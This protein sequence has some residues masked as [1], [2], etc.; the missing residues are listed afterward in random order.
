MRGHAL[1]VGA[2]GMVGCRLLEEL[3]KADF[4]VTGLCRSAPEV[5]K[6]VK[7]LEANL[8]D[9]ESSK[10]V[11]SKLSDITH[12]FYA[13]RASH[14]E[15]AVEPV[16]ENFAMLKNVVDV[17]ES[18]C[19]SLEHIH[20]VH[21][22]KYYGCHL[23]PYR[24]PA[25][26]ED[27]RH[28]GPNFYY[29]QQDY[30]M[31]RPGR[32]QWSISRP[33]LVYDYAPKQSRNPVSLIAV[34]AELS[35]ALGLPL[36]FPG[37]YRTYDLIA[38]AVSASHL[39]RAIVWIG[40]NWQCTNQAFNVT[41]GDC[42]RWANLWPEIAEFFKLQ[43]GIPRDLKLSEVMNDKQLMWRNIVE[44]ENLKVSDVQN[45]ARWSFGDFIFGQQWDLLMST[46]K[47]AATGF[48][49]VVDTHGMLLGYFEQ[50]RT[51]KIIP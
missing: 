37:S 51:A 22:A 6:N 39:A 30:L 40:T 49:E 14:G 5:S 24:T 32:W 46:T 36:E 19:P 34:Y 45:L 3:Q 31:S 41:N 33:S 23:G 16:E 15:G 13:A 48:K 1:V 29:D 17:V 4:R 26:E 21:G 8:L 2:T 47:L 35:R 12:I 38:E 27:P 20:V 42:F 7:Y 10:L 11:L 50:Y 44:R 25:R 18:F 9:Y 28:I 43:L